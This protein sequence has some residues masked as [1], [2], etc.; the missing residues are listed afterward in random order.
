VLPGMVAEFKA[1]IDAAIQKEKSAPNVEKS[2]F[3]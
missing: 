1:K 2:I 3:H